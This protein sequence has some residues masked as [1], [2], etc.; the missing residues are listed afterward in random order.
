MEKDPDRIVTS[1]RSFSRALEVDERFLYMS[2]PG[3]IIFCQSIKIQL[4][5][6]TIFEDLNKE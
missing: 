6:S 1:M 5:W 4:T 3:L 2:C